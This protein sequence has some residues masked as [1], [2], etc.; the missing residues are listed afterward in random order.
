M[1]AS[2]GGLESVTQVLQDLPARAG[3]ASVFVKHLDPVHKSLLADLLT[4][5][6]TDTSVSNVL[7]GASLFCFKRHTKE[8]M[9]GNANRES[10][11][12]GPA[13]EILYKALTAL[14]TISEDKNQHHSRRRE[15]TGAHTYHLCSH[16]RC[17]YI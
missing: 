12:E 10:R 7:S 3:M 9:T 2:A 14:G 8:W 15:R 1:G 5:T 16:S 13:E 6:T 11:H 17:D 4:R